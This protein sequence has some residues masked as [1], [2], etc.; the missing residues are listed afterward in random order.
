MPSSPAAKT[1][2]A[3]CWSRPRLIHYLSLDV[4]GAEIAVLPP[5]FNFRAYT[6]LT[7]SIERPPPGLSA[8][9]FQH[10]YLYADTIAYDV[11]FVHRTHPRAQSVANNASFEQVPAKCISGP[12]GFRYSE[13]PR[14][15]P[16]KSSTRKVRCASIFGC[17]AF[18]G[19]P[20]SKVRYMGV[21][22]DE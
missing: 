9:L 7:L 14:L 19:H 6:F 2:F 11:L 5:S 13:R 10:G 22:A 15:V 21:P 8:L 20:Q 18:P 4:E 16:P 12:G 17:C 1:A 3:S